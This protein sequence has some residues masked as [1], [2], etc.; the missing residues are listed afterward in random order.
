MKYNKQMQNQKGITLVAL[1]ITII[2]IV[3]LAA[4]SI[5]A[6]VNLNLKSA[7][8]GVAD[9]QNKQFE[10]ADYMNDI[11]NLLDDAVTKIQD[12][13]MTGLKK[14]EL[15]LNIGKYVDYKIEEE[16]IVQTKYTGTSNQSIMSQNFKW[17]I[18]DVDEGKNELILIADG[19]TSTRLK[20]KGAEGYNNVVKV[21]NDICKDGYSN[22]KLSATGRSINIKDIENVLS[23]NPEKSYTVA[24]GKILYTYKD[25]KE[26][27]GDN[28]IYPYIHS[29]EEY[30]NIDEKKIDKGSGT[31]RS[32]QN[33][34]YAVQEGTISSNYAKASKVE[35]IRTA[36][37]KPIVSSTDFKNNNY[38]NMAVSSI[39]TG[40]YVAS[41]CVDM[42]EDHPYPVYGVQLVNQGAF[43]VARLFDRANESEI[44]EK[45]YAIRPMVTIPLNKVKVGV[46]GTGTMDSAFTLEAR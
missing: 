17:R 22:S 26:Y 38:Y 46:K 14:E 21:L 18:W 19:V 25:S 41:R 40:Y 2:I 31:L 27:T 45:T 24:G 20:L 42:I 28:A 16:K 23:W 36:I 4:V 9:Y 43:E 10:E 44:V 8:D 15:K 30:S 12:I 33:T 32:S 11:G 13:A 3:I 39:D 35:P 34:Y 5:G 7:T 1:I 37:T 29:L 6:I